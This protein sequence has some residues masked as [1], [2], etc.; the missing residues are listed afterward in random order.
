MQE[1]KQKISQFRS[2]CTETKQKRKTSKRRGKRKPPLT[3]REGGKS[4]G[5]IEAHFGGEFGGAEGM[6]N[7]LAEL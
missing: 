7:L 1:M 3:G 4:M 6:K 5:E 2:H